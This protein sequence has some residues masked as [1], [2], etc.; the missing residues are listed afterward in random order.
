M[1]EPNSPEWYF[2]RY[3]SGLL[4]VDS[5]GSVV[6]FKA[7]LIAEGL[8]LGE[9]DCILGMC[10]EARQRDY[11]IFCDPTINILHPEIEGVT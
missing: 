1:F 10:N 11:R 5:V 2:A 7:N 9:T 8:R 6:L 4:E 3:G